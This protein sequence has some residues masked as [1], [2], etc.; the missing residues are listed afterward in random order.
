ML[1]KNVSLNGIPR[2]LVVDAEE[3]LVNV[4][5]EQLGLTGTKVGCGQGQCGACSVILDG[6]VVRSCVTSMRRVPDGARLTTVEGVGTPDDLHPIQQAL[7]H[8][9]AAQCGFC[10][11]GFVVSTKALLDDSADPSRQEVRDWFNAHRNACR[12]NGYK[13]IVDAVMDAAKVMRG[14]MAQEAL[15]FKM[16]ADGRIWGTSYP[17]PTAVGKVTGTIEYGADLGLRM[18]ADTMRLAIVRSEVAHA[19][20]LG[21]ATAEAEAMPGVYRVLTHK[22]V[23]GRNRI[24]GVITFPTNKGDGWDR[25]ILCDTKVFKVGDPIAIVC[26]D[27]EEHAKAAAAKVKVDLEVLPAYLSAQAAMAED[28][29][30]IHPGTPNVYFEMALAKGEDPKPLLDAAAYTVEG[31]FRLQ[32]QPHLT[33]ET[34][35]GFAYMDEEERLTIHSKSIALHFN[36]AMIAEGLGVT[37]DKL[38]LVQNP[39]GGTFGYKFSPT[40]E[41]LLGVAVLATGRPAYLRYDEKEHIVTTGKRSPNSISLRVGIDQD[42]KLVGAEY[43]STVDHGPYSELGDLTC[44]KTAETLGAGYDLPNIRGN[45]RTVCTNHAYG[46]PFRSFGSPESYLAF[47]SLLDD[48]AA[49]A[50]MDPLELRYINCYRPGAT[51]PQGSP[52]DVYSLPEMFDLLRPKYKEALERVRQSSAANIKKGVGIS[53]G[54]YTCGLGGPDGSEAAAELTPDGVT[55]YHCWEDHGQGAEMGVLGTAH[56][57][58]RPLALAPDQ[59]KQ[60]GNDTA[61]VPVSGP[62]ASSRQQVITGNAIRVACETLLEAMKKPDGSYRT[63]EEMVAEGIETK[64]VG[65]WAAPCTYG[66]Q[67]HQVKDGGMYPA[68]Q[69][70]LYMA[71]VAVN[72]DTGKTTVERYTAVADMGKINNK[73]V[74]DG[75]LWGG[76]AQ[77]VGLAL[78][79]DFEDVDRHTTLNACGLPYISDIPDDIELLYVQTPRIGPFGAGGAGELTLTAPHVAI[80]NAIKNATGVRI[81]RPPALPEKI[82]EGL[83]ALS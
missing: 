82:L 39:T 72:T 43:D 60:V 25:P 46:A 74:V 26:A 15:E 45:L 63:Y 67:Y 79:E 83:K 61:F 41:S 38:R 13:V 17:R 30:E 12:C 36:M 68:Y 7:I 40:T 64:H 58:L 2:V 54:I 24:S 52:P 80:L 77:G 34:D 71:E 57:A 35:V 49:K 33:I 70:C 42:G 3:K 53:L 22:D 65:A 16:P 37:M 50:G 56:E 44:W 59:I 20:I 23:K 28:A 4:I 1:K 48:L 29:L 78:S 62:S 81:H 76:I 51:T 21:I 32:R 11:P 69:Y 73:L 18:P 55:I 31:D 6:K 75:Q 27:T 5:R 47:E 9:G 14:E 66:D 19:N 10:M 8:H